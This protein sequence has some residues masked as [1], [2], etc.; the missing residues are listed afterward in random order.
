MDHKNVCGAV[1]AHGVPVKGLFISSSAHEN[2]LQ[3]VAML[4]VARVVLKLALDVFFLDINC[5]FS[6][7]LENYIGW[8]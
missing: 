1:C 8:L 2:F 3:Y 4:S 5:Q 7:H 6:K